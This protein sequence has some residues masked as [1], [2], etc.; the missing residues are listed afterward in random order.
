M[1]IGGIEVRCVGKNEEYRVLNVLWYIGD[2]IKKINLEG[3]L[4]KGEVELW[5]ALF[6]NIWII[7]ENTK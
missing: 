3:K 1:I 4:G 7:C 6:K 2:Y 5:E